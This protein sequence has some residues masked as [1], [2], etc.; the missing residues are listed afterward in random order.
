MVLIH[1][2]GRYLNMSLIPIALGGEIIEAKAR[3]D[4]KALERVAEKAHIK[5]GRPQPRFARYYIRFSGY[6]WNGDPTLADAVCSYEDEEQRGRRI[7]EEKQ[8]AR[9]SRKFNTARR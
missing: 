3:C 4:Y 6:G 7:E 5:T 8:C 9:S 1:I 2:K